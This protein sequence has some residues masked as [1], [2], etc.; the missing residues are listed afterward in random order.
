MS[1]SMQ[2]KYKNDEKTEFSLKSFLSYYTSLQQYV[3]TKHWRNNIVEISIFQYIFILNSQKCRIF[4]QV[5]TVIIFIQLI[6]LLH[7]M[8]INVQIR[9][10]H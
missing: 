2:E 4:I 7:C 8:F 5:Y 9:F 10:D 1:E 3:Q 6:Y